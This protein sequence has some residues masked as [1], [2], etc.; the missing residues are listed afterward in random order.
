MP[1]TENTM[2]KREKVV[3]FSLLAIVVLF[4]VVLVRAI[5]H[6]NSPDAKRAETEFENRI[7]NAVAAKGRII[8]PVSA[9]FG[10]INIDD[11]DETFVVCDAQPGKDGKVSIA[12]AYTAGPKSPIEVSIRPPRE[13][14]G[15]PNPLAQ[16]AQTQE[17]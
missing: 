12:E 15:C 17:R 10:K 11:A 16:T 6:E 13:D 8:A 3:Y 9:I 7:E 5:T 4:L 14:V 2:S 1:Q